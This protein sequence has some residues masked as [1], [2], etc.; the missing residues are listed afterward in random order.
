MTS[1]VTIADINPD[2]WIEFTLRLAISMVVGGAI[3]WERQLSGKAA[4][5]RTHTLVSLG[6]ALFIM[7]PLSLSPATTPDSVSRAIQGVATGIGFLGAGEIVQHRDSRKP[8]VYGLT[9]A[10]SIWV[11][12]ALGAL[13]ACGLWQICLVGTSMILTVLIGEKRLEDWLKQQR[14]KS[15]KE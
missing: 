3:G 10:A 6:T 15:S 7:V 9:S 14:I 2:D 1:L 4:G 11:T 5:L 12:A 13:A 8:H